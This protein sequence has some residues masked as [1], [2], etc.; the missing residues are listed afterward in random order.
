MNK[1]EIKRKY[2]IA[3]KKL[4]IEY[5]N[6]RRAQKAE[7]KTQ[8]RAM[9]ADFECDLSEYYLLTGKVPPEDP[10]KRPVLEE[11]GNAVTH[12]LG[13]LFAIA[14]F[15]LMIRLANRPAEYIAASIY[16]FGMLYMFSM[17]C[18]YHAFAHGSAVKRLFR[19]FDYTGVYMLIGAT[20]APP[21]LCFIGGTFGTVFAIVQWAIIILGITLI[22]VFGPTKLRKIHMPLYIALGWSAIL[23]LPA[24]IKGSFPLAMWI[25]GGGVAYTLGI[26]PFM[27]KSNV[28]HFVWHFFVL[29][30]AL[31]QWI[32][33]Y[34]Y[35]FLA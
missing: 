20:F 5:K 15:I 9:R 7:L 22:S 18:L 4:K 23:L 32:G 33:I 28:S 1:K 19:R 6:A 30:G 10:P 12:G 34:N 11:I 13:A 17:S 3:K 26:I 16:S 21:L 24:L 14:A 31:V 29:A 8:M 35:I 25:L 2:K 27:M